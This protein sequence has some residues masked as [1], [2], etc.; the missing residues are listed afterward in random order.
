MSDIQSF[1]SI[2]REWRIAQGY[3]Q[4]AAAEF[5]TRELGAK[6]P[7]KT[8]IDWEQARKQPQA[9]S[10]AAVLKVIRP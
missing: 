9:I 8:Y 2:L 4:E 10:L 7:L 1:C 3:T 6:V 5:L